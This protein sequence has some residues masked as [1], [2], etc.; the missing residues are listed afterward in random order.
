MGCGGRFSLNQKK[1]EIYQF[2][3]NN[4]LLS[5]IQIDMLYSAYNLPKLFQKVFFLK[6]RQDDSFSIVTWCRIVKVTAHLLHSSK[7]NI[8]CSVRTAYS[9]RRWFKLIPWQWHSQ[10]L[11]RQNGISASCQILK[12]QKEWINVSGTV[13]VFPNNLFKSVF[14]LCYGCMYFITN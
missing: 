7:W 4:L 2:T 9:K 8:C 12:C 11:H 5:M 14:A 10:F 13:Y 1:A 6:K 3:L